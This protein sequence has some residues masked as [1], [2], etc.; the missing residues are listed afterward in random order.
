MDFVLLIFILIWVPVVCLVCMA[1]GA[2]IMFCKQ[3]RLNPLRNGLILRTPEPDYEEE[4]LKNKR[5]EP[6]GFYE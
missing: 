2:Y 6:R 3:E 5:E 1:G 4:M